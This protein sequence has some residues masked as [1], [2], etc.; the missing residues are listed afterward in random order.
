M[1]RSNWPA[2]PRA[3]TGR[4]PSPPGGLAGDAPLG[5]AYGLRA[6]L[7]AD[8]G[9]LTK[10]LPDAEKAIRLAPQDYRGFLAR[11]RVQLERGSAGAVA[12][13]QTAVGL[14]MHADAAALHAYA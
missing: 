6:V 3:K 9:R 13:L 7:N 5:P 2:G 14:S 10:A 8:R 11:G 12:D 1:T 4:C